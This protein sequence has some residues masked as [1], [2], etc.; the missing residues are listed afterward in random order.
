MTFSRDL[1]ESIYRD[2]G[3]ADVRVS[4]QTTFVSPERVSIL[5][6]IEAGALYR[7]RSIKIEGNHLIAEKL[8][9]RDLALSEGQPFSQTQLYEANKRLFLS[10]YYEAIDIHNS[11]APVHQ[12]DI[13]VMVKERPTKY[14]KGGFGYGTETKRVLSVGYEDRNFFGNEKSNWT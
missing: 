3:Y 6:R 9:R 10:G 7:I 5:F 14:A 8:I 1:I 4:T 2:K 11:S 13:Q 12:M